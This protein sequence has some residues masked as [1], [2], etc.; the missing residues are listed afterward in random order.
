MYKRQVRG[1]GGRPRLVEYTTGLPLR[2]VG[3]VCEESDALVFLGGA[4]VDPACYNYE[5]ELPAN[6]YGV[7]RRADDYCVSL[8]QEGAS[9]DMPI[10]AICRGSVSY[11][12]LDVYKRQGYEH[13]KRETASD[14]AAH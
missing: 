13:G 9:R 8:L 12:H 1:G 4:D 6:L 7:D 14:C 2:P 10:L 5:G 3:D 11:T